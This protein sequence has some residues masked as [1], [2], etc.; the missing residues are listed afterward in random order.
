VSIRRSTLAFDLDRSLRRLRPQARR[1]LPD[2]DRSQAV[3]ADAAAAAGP[4]L[5][6]DTTVYIDTLQGRAPADVD[7]LLRCRVVQHSAVCLAELTHVFGRLDPAHRSTRPA[8]AAVADALRAIP[9]HR[10]AAPGPR[11]WGEAGILAGLAF[12]LGGYQRGQERALLNDALVLLQARK[13]GCALLT[14][15][16]ADHDRLRRLAHGS[17]VVFYQRP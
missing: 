12:R 16:I 7:R 11:V 9:P 4:P 14:A 1:H 10:L 2:G 13:Q 5:L 15:N 17:L 6:L 8:L 3:F